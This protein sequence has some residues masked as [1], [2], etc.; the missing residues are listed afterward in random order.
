MQK[1]FEP[2]FYKGGWAVAAMGFLLIA[3]VFPRIGIIDPDI[4][5]VPGYAALEYN[6][7]PNEIVAGLPSWAFWQLVLMV[8]G[9]IIGIF[10]VDSWD[11]SY[12]VSVKSDGVKSDDVEM[13][14]TAEP[15]KL[16]SW[17]M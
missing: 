13:E 3:Q 10:T 15:R 14:L 17:A 4:K 7:K 1:K 2:I 8:I 9:C 6:G 12:D 16:N 5:D 11:T